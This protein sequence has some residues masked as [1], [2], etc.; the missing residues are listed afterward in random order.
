MAPKGG[1]AKARNL[2]ARLAKGDVVVFLDDDTI[3]TPTWL[4]E[5]LK[6]FEKSSHAGIGG[7]TYNVKTKTL[8]EKLL[9]HVNHLHSPTDPVSQQ[10]TFLVTV[11]AAFQKRVFEEIG[12]F[13]EDFKLPCGE[14]IDFGYRVRKKGYTLGVAQNAVVLHHQRDT[15]KGMF[16]NWYLYGKGIYRCQHKHQKE[17]SQLDSYSDTTLLGNKK[18]LKHAND[19]FGLYASLWK[20]PEISWWEFLLIPNLHVVNFLYYLAG[21]FSEARLLRAQS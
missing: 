20:D 19:Y 13:D 14:D 6:A 15:L 7:M 21:R 5:I 18:L 1:P 2:G 9:H 16:K 11:N 4:E 12:G 17:L 8:S 3:P 10:V